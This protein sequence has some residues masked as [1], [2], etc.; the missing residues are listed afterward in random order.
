MSLLP[1]GTFERYV[2]RNGNSDSILAVG[3]DIPIMCVPIPQGARLTRQQGEV[4]LYAPQP[5]QAYHCGLVEICGYYLPDLNHAK[6]CATMDEVKTNFY[7]AFAKR[8]HDSAARCAT[9]G[10]AS[11]IG[12]A[13]ELQ[14]QYSDERNAENSPRMFFQRQVRLGLPYHNAVRSGDAN[15]REP[16][17]GYDATD[18][19]YLAS[20]PIQAVGEL[21]SDAWNS[22]V[23]WMARNPDVASDWQSEEAD[24][25][26]LP[27]QWPDQESDLP[28]SATTVDW[29][30]WSSVRVLDKSSD[31]NAFGGFLAQRDLCLCARLQ[32]VFKP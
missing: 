12:L 7:D 31:F 21:G 18:Y 26:A 22:Y 19:N 27:S 29:E 3:Q 23:L 6:V 10:D 24:L 25:F 15:V 28:A 9:S 4:L 20:V 8:M 30:R 17:T 16:S 1:A 14:R 5:V 11:E 2:D 32:G 13:G